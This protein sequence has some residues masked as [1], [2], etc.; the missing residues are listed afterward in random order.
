[1]TIARAAL[2]ATIPA[3]HP[4]PAKGLHLVGHASPIA[5]EVFSGLTAHPKT[6]SP[7]LFYDAAGSDLFEKITD[8]PEYYLTRAE[9]SIFT[10]H[11]DEIIQLARRDSQLPVHILEL[12]AGSAAKTGLLLSAAARAQGRVLY[13]PIDV[14]ASALA[15]AE[16]HL[17]ADLPGVDIDF[18]PHVGDYTRGYQHLVHPPGP[19]LA[20]FIGSS[21]GNFE[22]AAAI[23]LLRQLRSQLALEASFLIG[24]DLR[25][26]P[27]TLLAAY[28]DAAGVTAAFNK[29]VLVRINRELGADFDLDSFQ[30]EARW[31]SRR[32]RIE[33]HLVS[34][35]AQTVS[36]PALD[37]K[38][39]FAAGESIHTENSYKY[40]PRRLR[41][42]LAS[43]GFAP[44]ASWTDDKKQFL[45]TLARP[46]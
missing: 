23:E 22:P 33:M 39:K 16:L 13:Q 46:V 26:D 32:S 9:R 1:M 27:A 24:V 20:L 30:H 44:T 19:R 43:T 18:Q 8:L 10:A 7:W 5:A 31:N 21:I 29:N 17:Q 14:S 6:L 37:L 45:V 42:L 3:L 35:R 2:A 11:A 38:V 15:E 41:A 34:R 28:N 36:I 12:G 4:E 40:T 25:K